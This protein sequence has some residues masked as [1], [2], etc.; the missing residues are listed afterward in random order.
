MTHARL[1]KRVETLELH[2]E[3]VTSVRHVD[4]ARA[5]ALKRLGITTVGEL[6]THYPFRYIDLTQISSISDLKPG[7]DATVVGQV[8]EIHVKRPR[9]RLDI[10]EIAIT[11]ESGCILVGVWFNQTYM[12]KRFTKGDRVAFAGTTHYEFGLTQ[13]RNPFV[14]K[15]G[16]EDGDVRL[17]R[18]VPVHR[19][20][21]GLSTNWLRRLIASALDQYGDIPDFLPAGV[22][23][24]RG[25]VSRRYA[26]RSI[27]FPTDM[28]AVSQARRRLAYDELFCL[29]IGMAMRRHRLTAE[30]RGV[31]HRLDGP[32]LKTLRSQLPF[33]LTGDQSK[34]VQEILDDMASL[35]PMNRILIGD[36][37]TGKT[38]V[39]AHALAACADSGKQAAMMAP[40]EVLAFQYA[41]KIGP[42]LDSVGVRWSLL[43]GSAIAAEKKRILTAIADG[44]T[45]VV[46]GTQALL[47]PSVKFAHL[48]LAI[49]DEQHR[50]GVTQRLS[51]RGKGPAV[52]LLVMTAT[53]IP[54]SLALTFYGDLATSYLR[55]RPG[56]KSEQHVT[57]ELI[58]KSGRESAYHAIKQ[59]VSEGQQAYIVC[60]L[61]DESD[62]V[63]VRSA[64]KEAERLRTKVFPT[65]R[66][67][68]LT[69][70][71]RPAEKAR[72]MT[73]FREGHIDVL[74]STTVIE[75]GIDVPNA[76]IMI[77]ENGERYGLAQLHQLRGR[78]GRGEHPGKFFVVADPK[79]REAKERMNSIVAITDGFALAEADLALRGYGQLFG[80]R[81]SGLPE[82]KVASLVDD[83][84]ILAMAHDDAVA[85]VNLDP[86]LKSLQHRPLAIEASR[87]FG[88]AWRWVS[89]G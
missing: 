62:A 54:R 59:A 43:T 63:E 82:L 48:T 25:L 8:R 31:A 12:A 2:D 86:L 10:V 57:T 18:I 28:S 78:I 24:A 73:E 89:S 11:D 5:E 56:N 46:F 69:G 80:E 79:T 15:L 1:F 44:S 35:R 75:V 4:T 21:E 65:L 29:Q 88:P 36:V 37:G 83:E 84:G 60:A 40:T 9:P 26:L 17:S 33:P 58:S 14:E 47:E 32:A 67:G 45:H 30:R 61:V 27:H 87:R 70:R 19:T 55:Q 41:K 68:L 64:I 50:F 7:Q 49:V 51:L 20:T 39:A 85:V 66:V 3:P 74:V 81:Q 72:V 76:T 42:L 16:S 6:V 52:D 22:R 34:A 23:V 53:P 38:I 71:M 13:M 77:V